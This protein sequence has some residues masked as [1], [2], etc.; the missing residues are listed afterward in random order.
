MAW[1]DGILTGNTGVAIAVGASVLAVPVL[2]PHLSPPARSALKSVLTLVLEA[3]S[4]AEGGII[5]ELADA[6]VKQ[7]IQALSGPGPQAQRDAAAREVV[8]RY[9]HR[10]RSRARRHGRDAHDKDARYQRHDRGLRKAVAAARERPGSDA[11]ALRR[12]E[13]FIEE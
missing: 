4:I 10:A 9:H 8:R 1:V 3:E 2:V 5:R 13:Q 7:A 11:E 12:I 6:A